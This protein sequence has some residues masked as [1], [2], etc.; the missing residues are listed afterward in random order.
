MSLF[1]APSVYSQEARV[2]S[3]AVQIFKDGVPFTDQMWARMHAGFPPTTLGKVNSSGQLRM[4]CNGAAPAFMTSETREKG[5]LLEIS[6]VADAITVNVITMDFAAQDLPAD[7]NF[8]VCVKV[9]PAPQVSYN[10]R[11]SAPLLT[12]GPTD[13]KKDLGN[14][15]ELVGRVTPVQ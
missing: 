6:T 11:I 7:R 14:G 4:E 10:M 13:I 1:A 2:D 9:V 12:K 8:P 15:Y 5:A 3:V